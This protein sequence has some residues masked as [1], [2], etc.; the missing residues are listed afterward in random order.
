MRWLNLL[1]NERG[2]PEKTHQSTVFIDQPGDIYDSVDFPECGG[3]RRADLQRV[4]EKPRGL[5]THVFNTS[6]V[7]H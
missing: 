3:L 1:A 2:D 7:N 5:K 4:S 6:E